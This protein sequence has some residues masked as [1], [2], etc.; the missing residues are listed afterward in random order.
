MSN[1]AD[2]LAVD[3]SDTNVGALARLGGVSYVEPDEL[4]YPLGLSTQQLV[5]SLSNGL[6]GLLTKKATTAHSRG[7][8]GSGIKACVA[9]TGLDLH[10]SGHRPELRGR[11]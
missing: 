3:I 7:V 5:P 9:D 1:R 6:Y 8:T 4:R 2:A 10:A 11:H